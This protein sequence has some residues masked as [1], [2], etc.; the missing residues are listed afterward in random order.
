MDDDDDDDDDHKGKM[1]GRGKNNMAFQ[2][3]NHKM[4]CFVKRGVRRETEIK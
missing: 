1:T 2:E 3:E 4:L